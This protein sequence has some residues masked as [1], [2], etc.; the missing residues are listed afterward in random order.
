MRRKKKENDKQ[1]H[2]PKS[3]KP[4]GFPNNQ[5]VKKKTSSDSQASS[6]TIIW[7]LVSFSYKICQKVV[8]FLLKTFG[9]KQKHQQSSAPEIAAIVDLSARW[10]RIS[11]PANHLREGANHPGWIRPQGLL[12][13]GLGGD[14]YIYTYP[15]LR[16]GYFLRVD[17]KRT[18]RVPMKCVIILHFGPIFNYPFLKERSLAMI[19]SYPTSVN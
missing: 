3:L 8:W 19:R 12:K 17:C 1:W 7:L 4:N 14:I 9:L 6:F 10:K 18:L 15:L 16:L 11:T 5:L 13:G 2:E